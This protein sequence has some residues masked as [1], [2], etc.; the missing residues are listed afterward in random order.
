MAQRA[1]GG[2]NKG[3]SKPGV[4]RGRYESTGAWKPLFLAHLRAT[5][6]VSAAAEKAGVT[7][8]TVYKARTEHA[9]FREAWDDVMDQVIDRIEEITLN[10]ALDPDDAKGIT[11]RIFLLKCW[12]PE[13]YKE[14]V[15]NEISGPGGNALTINVVYADAG[16][17]RTTDTDT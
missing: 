7:R 15:Q 8:R 1:E 16:D 6:N 2:K 9:D 17:A 12:R 14:T 5:C 11:A 10:Q 3:G 13:R 4:K